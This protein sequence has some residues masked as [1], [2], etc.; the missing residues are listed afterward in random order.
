MKRY[1]RPS[2]RRNVSKIF[3]FAFAFYFC[4]AAV[5]PASQIK[6]IVKDTDKKVLS[7]VMVLV[8]ETGKATFTDPDGKFQIHVPQS[9]K[10]VV[11]VFQRQ[12]YLP[13]ER[14]VRVDDQL[15]LFE[16]QFTEQYSLRHDI[17]VTATS[18]EKNILTVPM[19]EHS[20]AD[21]EIRENIPESIVET[22][23]ETPGVSFIGSGGFAVTPSVR[24]LARRRVLVMVDGN[25]I[26]SDRRAG[27]SPFI[28]LPELAGR[29]EVVRSGSSVLY[30]SDAIGGVVNILT[31]AGMDINKQKPGKYD[32]NF[33]FNS[34]NKWLNAGITSHRDWGKWHLY[35][36]FQFS[37]ADDY[38]APGETILH[39][40]YTHYSG[41]LDISFKDEKKEFFLGYVGGFGKDEGKPDR[42]NNPDKYAVVPW[43]SDQMMRFGFKEK[44]WL[45][46][47]TLDFSLFV[48]P[49]TYKLEKIDNSKNRLDRSDTRGVN[50][51]IKTTLRKNFNDSFSLQAGVEWFSR[52][53][54]RME[55]ENV[56]LGSSETL[57]TL[58]L[59]NGMRNDYGIFLTF[60]YTGIPRFE[61]DGGIR[62]TF[63]SISAEI[64]DGSRY[65]EKSS[66]SPSFFLGVT[67]KITSSMS[68]FLNVGRAFRF[69]SL[70]ESFYTGL[71]G[72]KYV[73]GSPDLEPESSMNIDTGLKIASNKIYL[74]FYLFANFI[75]HMIERYKNPDDIY[76]YDN[77]DRGKIYGGE[78]EVRCNPTTDI[79]LFGHYFYYIGRSGETD[80]PLN[81]LPAPRL[82]LG[83][84]VN[85]INKRLRV[86]LNYLHSFKK[87]DPGPAE[88]ENDAYNVVD[89]KSGYYLTPGLLVYLKIANLFNARYYPNPDPDIPLAK[90]FGV[91][92][93]IHFNF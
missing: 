6:G 7:L 21:L 5:L 68:L 19:A 49:T 33:T 62:Y 86:E 67:H 70:G 42:E 29:I 74:G 90:G 32:L 4:M 84:K 8:K 27:T 72:R 24:G 10:N 78:I 12:G 20:V 59:G 11:L 65:M 77:I 1:S 60:D 71:T 47:G 81:D 46:K 40:G 13:E 88:V 28:V 56:D 55:N 35:S 37:R 9:M 15:N 23:S 34:V 89:I 48:N 38:A 41:I 66:G 25:R 22:L 30:G 39:S 26:T 31:R 2:R 80:D 83:G 54:I 17:S 36:G 93:G 82:L 76:T 53:D 63:F 45:K 79:D 58:P 18:W 50:L 75:D 44:S 61:I 87:T 43:E 69:P 57:S 85:L 91:S 51:G 64:D 14:A 3:L 73:I 16:I 92:A 52:R